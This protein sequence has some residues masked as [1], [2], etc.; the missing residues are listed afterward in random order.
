MLV[1]YQI[2]IWKHVNM[3]IMAFQLSEIVCTLR[4]FKIKIKEYYVCCKALLNCFSLKIVLNSASSLI[5]HSFVYL[6][7]CIFC[8]SPYFSYLFFSFP[9]SHTFQLNYNLLKVRICTWCTLLVLLSTSRKV[10]GHYLC[11]VNVD[12]MSSVTESNKWIFFIIN[13]PS[14]QKFTVLTFCVMSSF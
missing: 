3:Y 10:Q 5:L 4:K 8:I 11:S 1:W 13:A 14:L 12:W 9:S 6:F 2:G 7:I